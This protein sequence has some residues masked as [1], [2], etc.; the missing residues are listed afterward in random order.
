MDKESGVSLLVLT[1]LG[2]GAAHQI[3]IKIARVV[4]DFSGD[5]FWFFKSLIFILKLHFRQRQALI[6]AENTR[7]IR[8]A[9]KLE[10]VLGLYPD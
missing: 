2:E 4:G 10:D 9:E 8:R 3:R 5:P 6:D 1:P 7:L